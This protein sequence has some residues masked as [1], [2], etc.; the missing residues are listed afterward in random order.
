MYFGVQEIE[1]ITTYGNRWDPYVIIL[2]LVYIV[3]SGQ[4]LW[5]RGSRFPYLAPQ[6]VIDSILWTQNKNRN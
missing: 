5:E 4:E 6:V 1:S 2:V 3:V